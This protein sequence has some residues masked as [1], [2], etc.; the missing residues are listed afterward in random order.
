MSEITNE[1]IGGGDPTTVGG[2]APRETVGLDRGRFTH[3]YEQI[4]ERLAMP[5]HADL[6]KGI[7]RPAFG[8]DA[9][10][11]DPAEHAQPE[12]AGAFGVDKAAA[13]LGLPAET[14]A[15]ARAWIDGQVQF[16]D[17][18][19]SQFDKAHEAETIGEL[20]ALWGDKLVPNIKAIEAYLDTL[21]DNA[22]VLF[23]AA[24]D[25]NGKA[26]ANNPATLQLLLGQ[27]QARRSTTLSGSLDEQIAAIE[28]TMRTDRAAYNKD[29]NLQARLRELYTMRERAR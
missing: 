6:A 3:T 27:A 14:L 9:S 4:G 25:G 15:G 23:K 10:Q 22:G 7:P 18:Q 11:S 24:R 17:E 26:I 5:S 20:R 28:N 16:S 19:L 21:P 2:D 8:A 13:A 1:T 29:A 12:A